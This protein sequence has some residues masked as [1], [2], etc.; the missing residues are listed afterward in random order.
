MSPNQGSQVKSGNFEF[1]QGT[2]GGK[3]YYSKNQGN[4]KFCILFQNKKFIHTQIKALLNTLS[5][6]GNGKTPVV[7]VENIRGN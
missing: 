1:S 6:Q 4:F 2:Y 3:K 5:V 7:G